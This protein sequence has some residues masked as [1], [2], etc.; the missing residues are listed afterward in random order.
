MP[1]QVLVLGDF[2]NDVIKTPRHLTAAYLVGTV[3]ERQTRQK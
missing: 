1:L 3:I 2:G